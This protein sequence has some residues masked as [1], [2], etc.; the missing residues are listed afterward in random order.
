MPMLVLLWG[1]TNPNVAKDAPDIVL[2]DDN[3]AFI[4]NAV[5]ERRRMFD[6]IQKFVLHLS[7]ENNVQACTLLSAWL[8]KALQV[9]QF[10][11]SLQL[12]LC[13]SL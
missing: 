12:K 9:F 7:A 10:S 11:P 6:N 3:F 4:L 13:G 8:P 5:E 1:S 2:I